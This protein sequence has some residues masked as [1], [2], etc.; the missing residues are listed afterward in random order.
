MAGSEA[1]HYHH[2]VAA[3]YRARKTHLFETESVLLVV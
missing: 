1:G 3:G 2:W